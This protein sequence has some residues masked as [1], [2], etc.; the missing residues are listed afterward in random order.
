MRWHLTRRQKLLLSLPNFITDNTISVLCGRS[1][2]GYTNA[3]LKALNLIG[4]Y[5]RDIQASISFYNALGFE[6]TSNDGGVAEVRLGDM[7]LQFVA[8]ETARDQDVS[9]QRDAFGE[10]KGTSVYIHIEV[11]AIDAYFE[12]L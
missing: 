11:E 8:E 9:F 2:L 10:P 3:K 12:Q 5:V 6:L 7:R 1:A 4:L